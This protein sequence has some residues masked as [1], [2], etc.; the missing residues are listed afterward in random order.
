MMLAIALCASISFSS[1]EKYDDSELWDKV[2]NI[3]NRVTNLEAKLQSLNTEISSLKDLYSALNK[4]LWIENVTTNSEGVVIK[5]SDGS[6]TIIKNGKDGTNGVNGTN[7]K[8]GNTPVI[9]VQMYNGV[10]YWTQT[11]NGTTTW[12]TDSKGNK[13]PT[14]GES[15]MTPL[16]RVSS[17][18][19]W[20]VSYD[21]GKTYSYITDTNG[22]YILAKG[23][24]GQNGSSGK[25]GK[26]GDTFFK[27]VEMKNGYLIITLLDE[28]IIMLPLDDA[29]VVKSHQS[30]DMGGSV[31]WATMNVGAEE[32]QENGDYIIW[33]DGTGEMTFLDNFT[34]KKYPKDMSMTNISGTSRDYAKTKWGNDWRTPTY[35]EYYEMINYSTWTNKT[36]NGVKC[37]QLTSL[38][39]KNSIYLPYNGYYSPSRYWPSTGEIEEIKGGESEIIHLFTAN[40]SNEWEDY[41]YSK[42]IGNFKIGTSEWG[43][44]HT[45]VGG[46][47]CGVRAVRNK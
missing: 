33:G 20:Q 13:I 46:I 8:D 12:I 30:V 18:G 31:K 40:A 21:G 41:L 44:W 17:N 15:A 14:T 10:Y 22:N 25:D 42:I 5:F 45:M 43:Y 24:N 35:D 2:N 9:G 26:D 32:I 19:Y 38:I 11:V 37:L 16:L 23:T 1:C 6:T 27:S 7:G 29:T 39:T 4:K 47:K 36:V 3:D 28:T 34:E